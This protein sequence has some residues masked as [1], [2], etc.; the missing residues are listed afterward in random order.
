LL[1]KR[2]LFLLNAALTMAILD[3]MDLIDLHSIITHVICRGHNSADLT[4]YV[5]LLEELGSLMNL[6]GCIVR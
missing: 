1:V 5:V 2:I 3:L 4:A 6:F